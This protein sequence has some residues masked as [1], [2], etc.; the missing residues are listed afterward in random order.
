[1]DSSSSSKDT[2]KQ[3]LKDR[4]HE[5]PT[6]G[7]EAKKVK[8]SDDDVKD[9]HET[10]FVSIKFSS[11]AVSHLIKDTFSN[12]ISKPAG[13]SW[14]QYVLGLGRKIPISATHTSTP[15]SHD[16]SLSLAPNQSSQDDQTS[17]IIDQLLKCS[18]MEDC[19]KELKKQ[20]HDGMVRQADSTIQHKCSVIQGPEI[21]LSLRLHHRFHHI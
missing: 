11:Y 15:C 20:S 1:M 10:L 16:P 4:F 19:I 12:R 3:W 9:E 21:R 14:Q 2:Q 7:P 6:S 13:K 17:G 18:Q 5:T 8:F